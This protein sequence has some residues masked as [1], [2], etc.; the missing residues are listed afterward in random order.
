MDHSERLTRPTQ[1]TVVSTTN[2]S[3]IALDEALGFAPEWDQPVPYIA[4][5]H[6]W[7]SLLGYGAP[8]RYAQYLSVPFQPLRK[9][10]S[11]S[12]VALLT[13]AAP[14][15][16]DKGDQ[17]SRAPYNAAAKFYKVY[18]GDTTVDHD[19]RVSHVGVHRTYLTDD[20]NT[21]F[22]LPALRRAV[23]AGRIGALTPRF[24]GVPTNRSQRHTVEVDAPELLAR[25]REDAADVALLVANCPICHQSM[26]LVARQLES[27]GIATVVLG[28]AK[29]IVERCGVPRL[30]FSDFPLGNAAARPWDPASQDSTLELAL[31]V[32]ESAPGPRTTVQN[33]LRWNGPADWRLDYLNIERL[34]TEEIAQ[35]RAAND[36]IKAVAQG[37]R[38]TTLSK[39]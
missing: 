8:Y 35:R 13:T 26:S 17:S 5:T 39:E 15:Q 14:F 21:W 37:V 9:P 30:L 38:D 28:A 31:R 3:S 16:P 27:N 24:H 6:A 32:L 11:Q 10:L 2:N 20:A 34:S 1:E 29:D 25:C 36:Q 12:R 23:A 7:Y 33:P 19:L 22:P 4:R 18:S